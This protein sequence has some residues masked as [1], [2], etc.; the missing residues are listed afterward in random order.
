[1]IEAPHYSASGSR[2]AHAVALPDALFDGTV[3]ED[4]L[5]QTV[6]AH[7]ANQRQGTAKTK[8]RSFVSGGN[9]K[10]WKQKGTGRARQGSTRAPH[11]RG[12]GTVFGPI[13]RS[14]RQDVPRKVRQLARR[15]AFNAR[16]REGRIHVIDALAFDA[17]KTSMLA[18]LLARLAL[19]GQRTL[20]LTAGNKPAVYLSGRNMPFVDVLPFADASAY[21]IIRAEALVIERDALGGELPETAG[22][23][24][25]PESAG[26]ARPRRRSAAAA[27]ARPK[28]AS[29]AKTSR[30]A[31]PRKAA[32]PK[33]KGAAPK[34]KKGSD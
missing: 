24:G 13:P 3:N 15:S 27:K 29:K 11:W 20:V 5:H 8:T 22:T 19:D 32:A 33:A 2:H 21:D 31:A 6:K 23:A 26:G 4:V 25:G 1:M 9:Q 16:A 10:P 18:G 30:A 17:P 28:A 7:L 12:G 34:K 14:Y